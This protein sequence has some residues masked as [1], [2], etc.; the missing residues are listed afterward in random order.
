MRDI[1][2]GGGGSRRGEDG[3]ENPKELRHDVRTGRL[4]QEKKNM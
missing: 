4:G 3:Q 1:I 2:G